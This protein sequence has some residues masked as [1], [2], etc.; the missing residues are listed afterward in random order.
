[1]VEDDRHT[2]VYKFW[3]GGV[4]VACSASRRIEEC[5]DIERNLKMLPNVIHIFVE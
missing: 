3:T 4:K 2:G 5:D 1:M